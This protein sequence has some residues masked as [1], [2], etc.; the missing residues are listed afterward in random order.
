M[1]GKRDAGRWVPEAKVTRARSL[2]LLE[3]RAFRC[4]N[5]VVTY[6]AQS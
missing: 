1:T 4:R 2:R 5:V 6:A 3:Q